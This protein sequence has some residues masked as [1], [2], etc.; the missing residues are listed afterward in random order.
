MKNFDEKYKQ[1]YEQ[2]ATT[3]ENMRKSEKRATST[4]M[5]SAIIMGILI[6]FCFQSA[7]GKVWAFLVTLIATVILGVVIQDK[8]SP[9]KESYNGFFKDKVMRLLV[10]EYSED[11]EYMPEKGISQQFY[12]EGEFENYDIYTSEDLI[13]GVLEDKYDVTMAEV[14]TKKDKGEGER[15]VVLFWGIVIKVDLCKSVKTKIKVRQDKLKIWDSDTRVEMDFGEFEENF[16]V[17]TTDKIMAMQL[18]TADVMQMML[19]FKTKN[20]V[21]PEL[22]LKENF[23]MI[24]FATGDLFEA[25][26]SEPALN[27][28]T[29][30]KYYDTIDFTL[31]MAKKFAKNIEETEI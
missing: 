9:K 19:D 21:C 24:R 22:T 13:Q 20:N 16:D 6:S 5:I 1:I 4:I 11:L 8:I 31:D 25:K 29:L 28:E 26:L 14:E 27:Y 12:S 23:M 30:K 17:Y 2:Y 18:L 15:D 10:K 3:L 7:Y